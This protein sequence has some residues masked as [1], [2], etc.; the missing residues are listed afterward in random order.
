MKLTDKEELIYSIVG[1]DITVDDWYQK[2]ID[3]ITNKSVFNWVDN[4]VS[5][6]NRNGHDF[7]TE[8][9]RQELIEHILEI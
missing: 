1:A 6:L 5:Y 9:F 7:Y 2:I 8:E 4:Y 3:S